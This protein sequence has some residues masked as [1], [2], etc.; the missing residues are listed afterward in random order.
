MNYAVVFIYS[1]NDNAVYLFEK[2]NEA[3]KCLLETF[4]QDIQFYQEYG[5]NIKYEISED[6]WYGKISIIT[7]NEEEIIEMR[8]IPIYQ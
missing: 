5:Y 6:G 1:N 8:V 2:E 4:Q 3:K 7:S